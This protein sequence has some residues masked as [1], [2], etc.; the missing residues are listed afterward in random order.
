MLTY[1]FAYS[2]SNGGF[3]DIE[4][5]FDVHNQHQ[6][7]LQLPAWRPGRY[8]LG[9]FAKNLRAFEVKTQD[10]NTLNYQKITKDKWQIA[11]LGYSGKLYINYQ[12]YAQQLNAGSTYVSKDV[13]Y[14]NPV[15]CCMYLE[16]AIH[17]ACTL[18][19]P[20]NQYGHYIVPLPQNTDLSFTANDFHQLADT[21][22]VL[23][24]RLQQHSYQVAETKFTICFEGEC[25][26]N[27]D[28]LIKNFE[29][30]TQYMINAFGTCPVKDYYF[31][32]FALPYPAYHG[33]EH[34][35]STVITL[36]P[37]YAIMGGQVWE[38]LLGIASHELYHL[39]NVKFIRSKDILPYDYTQENYSDM[40][41]LCEGVTSYIG[42]LALFESGC[43]DK[44]Q[45]L[46]LLNKDVSRH[47]F[48][49]GRLL[50]SLQESSMDTWLDGYAKGIP[51]RTV[52]IYTEGALWS[53]AL[54]A[55]IRK[56]HQHQKNIHD[57]MRVFYEKYAQK[58]IG[59][60]NEIFT[61]EADFLT[62]AMFSKEILPFLRKK[63]S[64]LPLLKKYVAVFELNLVEQAN[65]NNLAKKFGILIQGS[66]NVILS[67]ALN[68]PA[69]QAALTYGM[70]LKQINGI[71]TQNDVNEWAN[72]FDANTLELIVEDQSVLKCLQLQASHITYYNQV[73]LEMKK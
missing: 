26:P 9:N 65:A 48:N 41:Y 21:P 18:H 1:T 57:L 72:Y 34:L 55:L 67:V 61:E 60:S 53:F 73:A 71:S 3:V 23:S 31:I 45:W 68:S 30:F 54:D 44:S 25:K 32:F 56:T 62:N 46:T 24:N 17:E 36:G 14:V 64:Y 2:A 19:L 58:G 20:L 16:G 70:Q 13:L 51:N 27:W 59:I 29:A 49:D 37:G 39:W 35:N 6:I 69:E 63:E 40:G 7:N 47:V 42:D 66:S 52:S 10:G 50:N 22:F 5:S 4:M 28:K 15:N 33:V 43:I 38:N 12:Y 11:T 8:E